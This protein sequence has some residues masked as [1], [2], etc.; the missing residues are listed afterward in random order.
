MLLVSLETIEP[1]LVNAL[2]LSNNVIGVC[3]C[4]GVGNWYV[5][6]IASCIICV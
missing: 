3:V 4:V 6:V 2:A 1:L 5:W